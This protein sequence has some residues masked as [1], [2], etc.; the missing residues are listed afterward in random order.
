MSREEY[1]EFLREQVK[2]ASA[3]MEANADNIIANIDRNCGVTITFNFNDENG[4]LLPTVKVEGKYFFI[5]PS[6]VQR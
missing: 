1:R 3:W 6:K 2:E 5:D 4:Q